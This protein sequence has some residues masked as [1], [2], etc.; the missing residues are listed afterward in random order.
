MPQQEVTY[1]P[2][3]QNCPLLGEKLGRDRAIC[4]AEHNH[5]NAVVRLHWQATDTCEDAIAQ[6]YGDELTVSED[7]LTEPIGSNPNAIFGVV[8]N[9]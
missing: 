2:M 8:A 6:F 9:V 5:H 4:T 1:I 7:W 3:C